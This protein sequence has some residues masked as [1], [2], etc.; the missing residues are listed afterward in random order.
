MAAV[1]VMVF[2][3]VFS[4]WSLF[5]QAHE[6]EKFTAPSPLPVEVS[7]LEG[8]AVELHALTEK[9]ENFRQELA[10]EGATALTLSAQEMNLAIAAYEPFKDLRGTLRVLAV[11]DSTLQLGI[12]FKLNGQPHLA[13]NG[14]SGWIHADPR[15][16][17]ATLIA[18][19]QLLGRELVLQLETLQVPGTTVPREFIGQMSPYRITER[20]L[21]DT[22]IGPAMAQLTSVEVRDGHLVL[23]RTPGVVPA[24]RISHQQV[25]AANSRL[26]SLLGLAACVLLG[27]AGLVV[28]VRSRRPP[29]PRGSS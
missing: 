20:Y 4:T 8:G 23:H 9:L 7:S 25:D 13:R 21:T 12:S 3:V 29:W 5:R 2:L 10:S 6:I 19:P 11:D 15:Y 24:D 22:R 14:E 1:A 27:L 17:N 26:F 18:R 16:L 28:F